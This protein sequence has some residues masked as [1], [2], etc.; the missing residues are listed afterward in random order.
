M[1]LPA[2]G[3]PISINSLVG[4]YG[5]S[6]SH[7]LSE[8]YRAGSFVA[9]HS[10]NSSVPT[11]GTISLSNFYGQ[12]NTAPGS[13]ALTYTMVAGSNG[14]NSQQGYLSGLAADGIY[15]I[16]SPQGSISN[17]P[18][19]TA[20]TSGFNPTIT[21]LVTSSVSGK[22]AVTD[23]TYTVRTAT[24]PNSGWTSIVTGVSRFGT[25]NR[26]AATYTTSTSSS[27]G[28]SRWNWSTSGGSSG[29]SSDNYQS[30]SSY[31]ITI[32]V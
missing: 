31:N 24:V 22:S 26:S 5:G 3:N 14:T 7:S 18:N 17:N 2:S 32:N 8:Y 19:G 29:N 11:S 21:G 16:S 28:R 1:T 20:L 10:N 9:N 12:S 30:G 4:E 13:T 23:L 27:N 25:Q 6:G 15:F